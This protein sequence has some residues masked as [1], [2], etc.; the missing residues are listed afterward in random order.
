MEACVC[1]NALMANIKIPQLKF[2]HHVLMDVLPALDLL[3]RIVNPVQLTLIPPFTINQ[4]V[5]LSVLQ[6]VLEASLLMPQFLILANH[7]PLN[8]KPV[9]RQ[10]LSASS[11]RTVQLVTTTTTPPTLA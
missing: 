7:A 5:T 2:V 8:A 4:L 1:K 6:H 10:P 11:L 3:L 9:R